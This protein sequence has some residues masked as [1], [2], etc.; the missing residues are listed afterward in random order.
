MPS[1]PTNFASGNTSSIV[2]FTNN[3]V[4]SLFI[5]LSLLYAISFKFIA[6][7]RV[8]LFLVAIASFIV[9]SSFL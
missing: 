5:S 3:E 7:F 6:S 4:T 8:F 2:V 9:A 1:S